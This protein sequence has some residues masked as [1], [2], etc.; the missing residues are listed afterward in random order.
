MW[1]LEHLSVEGLVPGPIMR[2]SSFCDII[3]NGTMVPGLTRDVQHYFDSSS[4]M[5]H[6]SIPDN[7]SVTALYGE[8]GMSLTDASVEQRHNIILEI[9][10]N[11]LYFIGPVKI[12]LLFEKFRI[13][14]TDF[15]DG[16]VWSNNNLISK[17]LMPAN[18]VPTYPVV[19]A[20]SSV[21]INSIPQLN[22]VHMHVPYWLFHTSE[23]SHRTYGSN[24]DHY[25]EKIAEC[26]YDKSLLFL[27]FKPRLYRMRALTWMHNK[28]LLHNHNLTW[29][30]V[31]SAYAKNKHQ[32]NRDA[33]PDVTLTPS[34]Q[35][36]LQNTAK[37]SQV[38]KVDYENFLQSYE[39]PR[40]HTPLD[41]TEQVLNSAHTDFAKYYWNLSVETGYGNEFPLRHKLGGISFLTEKTY[42]SFTQ[43]SMPLVLC[44]S[45]S[46]EYLT[47]QGFKVDNLLL[48]SYN[49]EDKFKNTMQLVQEILE[50][51]RKPDTDKLIHN[52]LTITDISHSA[53]IFSQC[54]INLI[55]HYDS[56][57]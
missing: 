28:G 1:Y 43:A 3:R 41:N 9:P 51:S 34:D 6:V 47:Q 33:P 48:D 19:Y 49:S 22:L 37:L 10:A 35:L 5:Q 20:T 53:K 32:D 8:S 46:Y 42:K 52:F 26:H 17:V 44:D 40:I 30:L 4:M 2:K 56:S 23:F 57:K 12:K 14:I 50:S 55:D 29:S 18:T 24:V 16:G 15:E 45:N 54:L 39:F 38:E 7:L 21:N 13:V 27:N 36:H 31:D 11:Y 25:A